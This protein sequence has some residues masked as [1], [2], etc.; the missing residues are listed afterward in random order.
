MMA[1]GNG[2]TMT[3][4]ENHEASVRCWRGFGVRW[5]WSCDCGIGDT[6]NGRLTE[7]Q[8]SA[9]ATRHIEDADDDAPREG[10]RP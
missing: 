1:D 6:T 8:A 4:G 7:E 3:K 5:T 9:Q 2:E 10:V